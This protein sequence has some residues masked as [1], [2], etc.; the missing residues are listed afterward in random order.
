MRLLWCTAGVYYLHSLRLAIGDRE[1]SGSDSAE[2]GAIFLLETVLIFFW[3][4][5]FVLAIAAAG[6]AYA[7][8]YFVVQENRQVGLKPSTENFVQGKHRFRS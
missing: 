7:Y 4:D 8:S 1:I 6:A 2:K 3:A 5:R